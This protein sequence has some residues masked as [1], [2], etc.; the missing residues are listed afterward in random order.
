MADAAASPGGSQVG[1]ELPIRTLLDFVAWAIS[2][3]GPAGAKNFLLDELP[4]LGE[5]ARR[6][7]AS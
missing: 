6:M 1:P 2:C 4:A 3:D 7:Q 5:A